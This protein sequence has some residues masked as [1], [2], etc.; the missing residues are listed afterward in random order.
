LVSGGEIG[1]QIS[2][3]KD[4]AVYKEAYQPA[5]EIFEVSKRWPSE[6][7]YSLTDQIRRASQ[8]VCTNLRE[9]GSASASSP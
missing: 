4:L 9:A 5:M 8:S 1:I 7:K 3:V 6:E 2:P